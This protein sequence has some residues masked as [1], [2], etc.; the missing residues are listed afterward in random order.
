MEWFM[1]VSADVINWIFMTRF[2]FP[3][4]LFMVLTRN[5]VTLVASLEDFWF[6]ILGAS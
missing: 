1:G 2:F 3:A 6:D 4:L 5:Q